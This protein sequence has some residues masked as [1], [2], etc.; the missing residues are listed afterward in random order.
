MPETF[1]SVSTRSAPVRPMTISDDSKMR[2]RPAL[3]PDTTSR[4]H[5]RICSASLRP[6]GLATHVPLDRSRTSA[7]PIRL[8]LTVQAAE[9]IHAFDDIAQLADVAG[10]VVGAQTRHEIRRDGVH[11]HECSHQ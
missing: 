10:P 6:A 3:G 4:R 8:Y 2:V 5:L 9:R 1:L 7:M 11:A